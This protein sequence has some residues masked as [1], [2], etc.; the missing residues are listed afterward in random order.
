MCM[1]I[2]YIY[3]YMY[4]NMGVD[5]FLSTSTCA[6]MNID[7]YRLIEIPEHLNTCVFMILHV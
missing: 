7:E 5:A 3:I 4:T 2:Q 1:Y 6:C